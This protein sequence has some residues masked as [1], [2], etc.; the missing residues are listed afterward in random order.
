[1]VSFDYQCTVC[2]RID[3]DV[4]V[5]KSDSIHNCSCCNQPMKKYWGI[6]RQPAIKFI[7]PGFYSNDNG[8]G[9]S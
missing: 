5:D 7:G 2:G 8:R 4:Y 1:M 9:F 6:N 3:S